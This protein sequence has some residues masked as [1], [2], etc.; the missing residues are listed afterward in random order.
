MGEAEAAGD[1]G[2]AARRAVD[3]RDV[4]LEHEVLRAERWIEALAVEDEAAGVVVIERDVRG[5]AGLEA[6][7]TTAGVA[8]QLDERV[9]A[10][11]RR[12][13][14]GLVERALDRLG[15]RRD[16]EIAGGQ[17]AAQHHAQRDDAA[18][19][20]QAADRGVLDRID[21]LDRRE[22]ERAVPVRAG[23]GGGGGDVGRD[24]VDR[25]VRE[26]ERDMDGR[27]G[28][29]GGADLRDDAVAGVGERGEREL[30]GVGAMDAQRDVALAEVAALDRGAADL[31]AQ[32]R[33]LARAAAADLH[34]HGL[35][36]DPAQRRARDDR[37]RAA[38]DRDADHGR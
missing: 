5:R 29:R 9:I 35:R 22:L 37:E 16:V 18:G 27:R 15:D 23:D 19:G 12:E 14:R 20:R 32:A 38:H 31:E 6:M 25:A 8:E 4:D 30:V 7:R 13:A 17:L 3:A 11:Q 34:D 1:A 36:I 28:A 26:L 24:E 21:A 10:E 2:L 33:E